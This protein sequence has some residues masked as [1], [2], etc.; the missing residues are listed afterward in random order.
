MHFMNSYRNSNGSVSDLAARAQSVTPTI[1]RLIAIFSE[2]YCLLLLG[3][4]ASPDHSVE[5]LLAAIQTFQQHR[6][7]PM[8][9]QCLLAATLLLLLF[10]S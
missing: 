6:V 3:S 8:L 5:G 2:A 10:D 9:S 1:Y 7:S 4:A